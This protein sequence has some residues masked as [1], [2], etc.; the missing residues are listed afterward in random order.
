MTMK[1]GQGDDPFGDDPDESAETAVETDQ[2]TEQP[3]TKSDD[4][5]QDTDDGEQ[6]PYVVRRQRVK[7]ERTNELVA[8]CRD[9]Y[10]EMEDDV[11]T[12]VANELDM[13]EK[14]VSVL[15]LREAFIELAI[16]HPEDVAEILEAWGY[17]HLK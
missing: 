9:E 16:E 11:L 2:E 4:S 14:D 6:F 5:E 12:A 3:Q 17:E 13:R 1:T 8:F 10:A 15:D 7:D